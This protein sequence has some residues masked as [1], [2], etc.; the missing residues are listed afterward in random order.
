MKMSDKSITVAEIIC[1]FK[2]VLKVIQWF[3]EVF[4]RL[5]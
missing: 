3:I 4:Y 2:E 5:T 1:L